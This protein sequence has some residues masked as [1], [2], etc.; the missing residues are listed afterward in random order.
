MGTPN[1]LSFNPYI[2]AVMSGTRVDHTNLTYHFA[3]Q[4]NDSGAAE[5]ANLIITPLDETGQASFVKA[6][7]CY[8]S[9]CKL[10]FTYSATK[11]DV[12]GSYRQMEYTGLG[13]G[14]G[15][16][17][18]DSLIGK[19]ILHGSQPFFAMLHEL[20]HVLGLRHDQG[21]N[22]GLGGVIP[23]DHEAHNY[24][25]MGGSGVIG[26]EIDENWSIQTLGID[27]IRAL[28]YQYGA[29][30][31][32]NSG[33]TTYK[34]DPTTGEA[35]INEQRQGLPNKPSIVSSLWDG[36]GI[37]TYDL[38]NF[39]TDMKI[40]LRPGQWSLFSS[41]LLQNVYSPSTAILPGNVANAYLYVDPVTGREDLRSLIEN[42]IGGTGNDLLTGN[43]AANQ[44]EGRNGN[45]TL[46]G[47]LGADTL[48][49]GKGNDTYV[50]DNDSDVVIELA[51]EGEGTDT[52]NSYINVNISLAKYANI[53]NVTLL[54]PVAGGSSA[55]SAIGNDANNVLI[56]ND[57]GNLL[58]GAGG[59]DTLDGGL[60][61]DTMNGGAGDDTYIVD[62][63]RDVVQ[64][65]SGA[66]SGTDTV[67]SYI[68]YA[69]AADLENLTLLNA[70]GANAPTNIDATGNA[71]ANKIIGNDGNN[72]R[73]GSE[74][75]DRLVK[76][77]FR[78]TAA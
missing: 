25:V 22:D 66:G 51:G 7:E 35:Y 48:I 76:W 75:L 36:G 56:G 41:N 17:L 32:N 55:L 37:D 5:G 68:T 78:A 58:I 49:G 30:F 38:S 44:L 2:D 77:T 27:D 62:N 47:G 8:S 23:A 29:N 57:A 61:A 71:S 34:W 15:M 52:I 69:L 20:G 42:A 63:D 16:W 53:E 4:S 28:Q 10:T 12:N 72:R 64:E 13:G 33:N 24:S 40:D 26:S 50:I 6:L 67:Q 70:R 21:I 43:Q 1:T 73:G 54:N 31:N 19:S 60:G 39:S 11:G 59:A 3:Q 14:S 9:V 18:S 45:D 46:D 74:K 65:L